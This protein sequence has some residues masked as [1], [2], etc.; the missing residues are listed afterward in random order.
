MFLEVR[1]QQPAALGIPAG[2]GGLLEAFDRDGGALWKLETVDALS[3]PA[4]DQQASIFV[5]NN[6]V[7]LVFRQLGYDCLL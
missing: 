7:E 1:N 2:I 4:G 3:G 5:G 6:A